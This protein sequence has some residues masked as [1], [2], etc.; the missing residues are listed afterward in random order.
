MRQTTQFSERLFDLL[1]ATFSSAANP[2]QLADLAQLKRKSGVSDDDWNA[3]LAYSAQV[4]P[5]PFRSIR[6]YSPGRRT[7]RSFPT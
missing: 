5:S 3:V 2:K 6:L 7:C 1:V 4:R